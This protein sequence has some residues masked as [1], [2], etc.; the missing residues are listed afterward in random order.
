M[1][2][3]VRAC[4]CCWWQWV[5]GGDVNGVEVVCVAVMEEEELLLV[6]RVHSTNP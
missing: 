4:A 1:C 2:A 5:D 3:R 6:C